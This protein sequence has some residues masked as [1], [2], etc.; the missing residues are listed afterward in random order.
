MKK[1]ILS[2]SIF[3]S[4]T[5]LISRPGCYKIGKNPQS[6]SSYNYQE[7]YFVE[8]YCN[9]SDTMEKCILCDH[10]HE[11]RNKQII[12]TPNIS[13]KT[14]SITSPPTLKSAFTTLVKNFKQLKQTNN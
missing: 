7:H 3:L 8:C 6:S 5:I 2:L 9:C 1:V 4:T 14:S 13:T 11:P 10:Y 12:I